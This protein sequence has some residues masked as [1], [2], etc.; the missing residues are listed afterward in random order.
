MTIR[1]LSVIE[2][3]DPKTIEEALMVLRQESDRGAVLVAIAILDSV[4]ASRLEQLLS[5][6]SSGARSRL[7]TRSLNSFASK[8]DL[9]YCIGMIPRMLYEDIRLLNKLRNRCAHEWGDFR[10]TQEIVDIYIEP[11]VMK[12]A[13]NAANKVMPALLP[14]GSPPKQIMV[15]TLAALV[16]LANLF[17][18][19]PKFAVDAVSGD[20]T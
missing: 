20:G 14:E 9:A 19:L 12:R 16:T 5:K 11:M 17:K 4:F 6:G 15:S 7:L 8:V 10:V 18:P 13:L 1:D 3:L 2:G